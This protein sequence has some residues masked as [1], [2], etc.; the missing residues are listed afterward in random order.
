MD[1]ATTHLAADLDGVA[2]LVALCLLEAPLQLV[3]PGSMD[4]TTRRFWAEHREEL[5]RLLPLAQLEE[6]L[7]EEGAGRLLV[8]DTSD[9]ARIGPIAALIDRFAEVRTFDT[10]PPAPTD[11]PRE[12]MPVAG[13]ATSALVLRIAERGITPSQVEA[14]LFLLGIHVDTGHFTF[15]GT[16]DLDHRA[17]A[18]CLAWGAPLDYLPRYVPKGYT[19]HQ[20]ALL[21]RIA[22]S[23]EM[24]EV[25][26]TVVALLALET[27]SYEPD[28]SVLLEQLRAAE[29]WPAAILLASSGERIDVIG[30]SE[31]RIDVAQVVRPLGGGG[32]AEAASASLKGMTLHDARALVRQILVEELGRRRVAA[33]VAVRR[34]HAIPSTSTVREA[35]DLLHQRRI[36]SL[37]LVKG[38]SRKIVGLVSRQ[39]VEA[40]LRHGLGDRPVGEISAGPPEWVAPE[41]SL[42]DARERLLSGPKRLVVVGVPPDEVVGILTRGTLFRAL[43]EP[44]LAAPVKAPP[45]KQVLA[46]ARDGLGDRW[47]MVEA[48]GRIGGELG[49]PVHLVGGTVRDLLLGLPVRDVDLVVEGQGPRLAREAAR[50]FGGEVHVHEAFGTA[51]WTGPDGRCLDLASARSEHYEA[52]AALPQVALHAGLRQD[53]FRRDFTLNAIAISVD[54]VELGRVHD[55]FGGLGDLRGGVLR[56]LHGLSFHDDPTRA[57]RAARFGARFDFVLAPETRG[58]LDAARKA[59]AFDRLSKERIGTELELILGQ[60]EVVQSFRLLRS[61]GLLQLLHPQFASGRTFLSRLGEARVA[62]HRAEGYL[63]DAPL[64]SD[65]LWLCVGAAIPRKDREALERLVPGGA[66]RRRRFREG[67]ERAKGAVAALA[68]PKRNAAVARLL[69]RLDVVELL[70]AQGIAQRSEVEERIG[71]WLREGRHVRSAVDG[72]Q[73]LALG[74][75]PGPQVGR[76]LEVALDAARDGADPAAQLAAARRS[77][78]QKRERR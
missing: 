16:S 8:A 41:S 10:H 47:P 9:P 74:V 60:H 51:S 49:L 26:G 34:F 19:A 36:N 38:R 43:E 71:W 3:L 35:A 32:H 67:P 5:P 2:S 45:P 56:V 11:L 18:Q 4:P 40:A 22:R 78:G 14:G 75:K 17:A 48:L 7:A 24:V 15:P 59:G 28:L 42:A 53:L 23:R 27:E 52:L 66:A 76:A 64:Q 46:M 30:R 25:P 54:P 13:A 72:R 39:E 61:W 55:P 37:P 70:Y 12:P 58:L 77:L 20:L 68:R 57:F 44:A 73:L 29:G 63:P 33:D 50:R 65:V 31:G 69:E 62:H 21:E 1:V 6:R